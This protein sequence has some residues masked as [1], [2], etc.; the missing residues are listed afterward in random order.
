[1][2]RLPFVAWLVQMQPLTPALALLASAKAVSLVIAGG[3]WVDWI[4]WVKVWIWKV[5]TIDVGEPGV[6]WKEWTAV[7]AEPSQLQG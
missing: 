6:V 4:V 2:R 3:T 7:A 5:W 1:M